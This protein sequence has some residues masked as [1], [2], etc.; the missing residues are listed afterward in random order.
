MIS[1]SA[2]AQKPSLNDSAFL[3]SFNEV[4]LDLNMVKPSEK[5]WQLIAGNCSMEYRQRTDEEYRQFEKTIDSIIKNNPGEGTV[6]YIQELRDSFQYHR[7]YSIEFQYKS[8]KKISDEPEGYKLCKVRGFGTWCPP[9]SCNWFILDHSKRKNSVTTLIALTKFLGAVDNPHKAYMLM[10]AKQ[11][12]IS[13]GFPK[14][15]APFKYTQVDETIYLIENLRL[16]DCPVQVYKCMIEIRP[17]GRAEIID[18]IMVEEG[19][20]I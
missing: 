10:L 3:S 13:G 1:V 19:G 15:G 20:C 14:N 5:K 11:F 7:K 6:G 18:K 16:S 4:T 17:D 2:H 8:S 9:S 12:G